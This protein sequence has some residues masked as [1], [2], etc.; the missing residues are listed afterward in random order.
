MLF[1][2]RQAQHERKI[3]MAF[4]NPL[5]LSLSKGERGYSTILPL[6]CALHCFRQRPLGIHPCQVSTVLGRGE[7]VTTRFYPIGRL[8]RGLS[9]SA[10]IRRLV[11]QRGFCV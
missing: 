3:L 2:L 1:M 5:A 11:G 10:V 7:N 4:T 8:S 6:F 9:Q